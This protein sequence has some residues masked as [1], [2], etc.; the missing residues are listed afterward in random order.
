MNFFFK[1][2]AAA[3]GIFSSKIAGLV[4]SEVSL[5]ASLHWEDNENPL[6]T[7]TV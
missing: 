6:A 7:R 1:K 5:V 3:G 4:V 2:K